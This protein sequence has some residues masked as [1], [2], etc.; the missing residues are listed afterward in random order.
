MTRL[1]RAVLAILIAVVVIVLIGMWSTWRDCSA[2]G[3]T[4]VRGLFGLECIR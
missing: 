3:G 1:E 2:T 4:T